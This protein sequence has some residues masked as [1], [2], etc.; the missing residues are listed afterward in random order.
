MGDGRFF[1]DHGCVILRALAGGAV[2]STTGFATRLNCSTDQ[3]YDRQQE[4]AST[5]RRR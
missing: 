2:D 4:L 3:S 5:I 1:S